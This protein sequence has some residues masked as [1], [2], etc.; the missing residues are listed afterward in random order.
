MANDLFGGLGTLGGSLSGLMCGLAK[1]GLVPT[2]TPEGKIL[3]IKSELS[4][5]EKQESEI[6]LEIGRQAYAQNPSAW[7]QDRKLRLIR[8]NTAEAERAF[9][10]AKQEQEKAEMEKK[11]E[12]AKEHCPNCGSKNP[13]G[14][15]FCQECG[16]PL[17]ST[18]SKF[19][20]SCG[21]ELAPGVRFCGECGSNQNI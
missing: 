10:A 12:K 3:A 5:L 6:M 15:R 11:A 1:S 19:C 4:D 21:T 16:T 7:P 13:D 9:L 14:M 17:A 8:Q 20:A 2:D 18:A